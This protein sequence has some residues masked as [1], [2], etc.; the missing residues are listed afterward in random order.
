[1]SEREE[2]RDIPEFPGYKVSNLG[3]VGS[4]HRKVRGRGNGGGWEIAKKIQ[5]ILKPSSSRKE[6]GYYLGVNLS[7]GG[8]V[9]RRTI[10]FLVMIAFVGVCPEGLEICHNNGNFRDNR[11]SNLRYDT[12]L[13]NMSEAEWEHAK[14][15]SLTEKQIIDIREDRFAGMKIDDIAEKYKTSRFNVQSICWGETYSYYAGPITKRRWRHFKPDDVANIRIR[16]S[17][18]ESRS[19]V[20]RDLNVSVATV[21]RIVSGKTHKKQSVILS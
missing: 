5:R 3:R 12:H 2:W 1:M 7:V 4:Y 15:G 17:S 11:L 10:H 18:G 13:A 16:V 21:S 9:H 14:Q 8:I 6:G 20:A 19:A